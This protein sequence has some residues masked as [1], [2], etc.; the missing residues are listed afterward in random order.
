M[1]NLQADPQNPTDLLGRPIKV[2]DVVGW[3]TTY[4]KSAALCIATI[5][6][7][8]FIRAGYGKNKEVPQAQA[9][10]YQLQ[11]RP[12]QTTG[13]VSRVH[14][15]TGAGEY[16][17]GPPYGRHPDYDIPHMWVF[18][19]KTIHHVKNVVLLGITQ[20]EAEALAHGS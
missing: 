17:I 7:I 1:P 5:E 11:L 10:G 4:G 18:K 8:R 14:K 13:G 12:I 6:K 9:D 16:L 15:D 20:E 2:G 3:G 19:T